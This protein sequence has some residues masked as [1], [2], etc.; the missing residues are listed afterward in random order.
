MLVLD[1][2]GGGVVLLLALLATTEQPQRQVEGGLLLD[3]VAGQ[4]AVILQRVA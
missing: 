1:L 4:S 3:G 2:L